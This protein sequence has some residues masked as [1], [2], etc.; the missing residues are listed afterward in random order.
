MKKSL[1]LTMAIVLGVIALVKAVPMTAFVFV[2]ILLLGIKSSSK[3]VKLHLLRWSF[4]SALSIAIAGMKYLPRKLIGEDFPK[5]TLPMYWLRHYIIGSGTALNVPANLVKQAKS[6]L[7]AAIQ[8]NDYGC[9]RNPFPFGGKYCVNHSTLYEGRGFYGRPTLFYLLGGFSFRLRRDGKVSGKD[10]YDWHPTVDYNGE[11][12][13]FTSPLGTGNAARVLC[14]FLGWLF[15]DKWFVVGGFPSGESGISNKLW[16]DFH[17]VGAKPFWSWFDQVDM[18]WSDKDVFLMHLDPSEDHD[19]SEIPA[20]CLR[21]HGIN[22]PSGIRHAYVQTAW[23][24]ERYVYD[25]SSTMLFR[26]QAS[27]FESWSWK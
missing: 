7:L 19:V 12:K 25:V 4:I 18:D 21:K 11:K 1:V 14:A 23:N 27:Y 9:R 3:M 2:F 8:A 13:Y 20:S 16:D 5:L 15:D 24:G 17:A 10:C 6:A 26:D 22:I